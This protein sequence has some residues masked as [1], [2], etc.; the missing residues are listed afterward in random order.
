[1]AALF[2]FSL[3]SIMQASLLGYQ[4][5]DSACRR[6]LKR[7]ALV[8]REYSS[9]QLCVINDGRNWD[10]AVMGIAVLCIS[11]LVLS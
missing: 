8:C 10:S 1:M 9:R 7:P 4:Q 3:S 6:G 2:Q 5:R 11:P